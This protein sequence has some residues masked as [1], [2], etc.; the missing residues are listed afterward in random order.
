MPP[1]KTTPE[2]E[3][4]TSLTKALVRVPKSEIEGKAKAYESKKARRKSKS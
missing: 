4:F 2:S 3:R 1:K